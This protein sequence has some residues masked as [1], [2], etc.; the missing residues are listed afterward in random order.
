MNDFYIVLIFHNDKFIR[1]IGPFISEGQS[2]AFI[3]SVLLES[4]SLSG[5]EFFCTGLMSRQEAL[6][7][8]E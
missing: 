6:E 8:I 1:A 2:Q 4:E 3:D 5:C 7:N